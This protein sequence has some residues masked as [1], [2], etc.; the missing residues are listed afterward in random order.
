MIAQSCT[1]MFQAHFVAAPLWWLR[2][3]TLDVWCRR[4]STR[5]EGERLFGVEM[6]D[7][8]DWHLA[9]LSALARSM[10]GDG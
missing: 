10:P 8:G 2:R 3:A 4:H 9:P 5:D 1:L 6:N 7:T